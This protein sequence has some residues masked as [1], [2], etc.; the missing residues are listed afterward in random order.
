MGKEDL[1]IH[2]SHSKIEQEES[3]GSIQTQPEVCVSSA[4]KKSVTGSNEKDLKQDEPSLFEKRTEQSSLLAQSL[5][6][7]NGPLTY[8]KPTIKSENPLDPKS[9]KTTWV[10]RARNTKESHSETIMLDIEDRRKPIQ[11]ED[12]RPLKRQAMSNDEA[13]NLIQMVVAGDQPHA[14]HHELHKLELP[15][16][17]ETACSS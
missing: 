17:G 13:L 14:N 5:I 8:P 12:P 2:N 4:K 7:S 10:R 1:D 9:L 3:N 15:W 6:S 11:S 16:I